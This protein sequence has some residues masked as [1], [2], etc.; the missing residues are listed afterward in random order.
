MTEQYKLCR[1]CGQSVKP[2]DVKKLPDMYDHAQGCPYARK[3]GKLWQRHM[4]E[5]YS[6]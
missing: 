2:K 6:R 3:G 5:S 4:N 1:H